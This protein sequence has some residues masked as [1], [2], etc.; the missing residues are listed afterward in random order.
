MKCDDQ[1]SPEAAFYVCDNSLGIAARDVREVLQIF[2]RL[3]PRVA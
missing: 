3:H 1:S 2:H